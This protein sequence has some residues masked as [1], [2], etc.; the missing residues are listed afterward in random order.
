MAYFQDVKILIYIKRGVYTQTKV[1]RNE[2][3]YGMLKVLMGTA[4][5]EVE[6]AA[7]KLSPNANFVWHAEHY[8]LEIDMPHAR[9]ELR[10]PEVHMISRTLDNLEREHGYVWEAAYADLEDYKR[11][12]TRKSNGIQNPILKIK[13]RVEVMI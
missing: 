10:F 6:V 4:Y 8:M 2:E 3:K 7:K 12:T 1:D 5:R 13:S 9:W 11:S